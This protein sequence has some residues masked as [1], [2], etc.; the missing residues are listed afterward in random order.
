MV[1]ALAVAPSGCRTPEPTHFGTI[2]PGM[3]ERE[4]LD[5][6]GRPSSRIDAPDAGPPAGWAT[7][8]HW[9]DT[10]GTLATQATMPDQPPP[11]NVWTV[12]FNADG[13]VV[14]ASP[15]SQTHNQAE[16]APWEPPPAPSR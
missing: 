16:T 5:R 3:T 15:P 10:L 14:A 7:R 2:T 1:I 13:A 4:V 8:W 6:L 11:P 12:W 9:G